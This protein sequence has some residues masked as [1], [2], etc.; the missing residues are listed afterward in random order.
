M[1]LDRPLDI[2]SIST[3]EIGGGAEKVARDLFR[4]YREQ[5]HRSTLAVGYKHSDDPDVVP[6][7][8]DRAGGAASRFFWRLHRRLQPYYGR[9]WWGTVACRLAHSLAAPARR[10]EIRRGIEDFNYPGT[11][12]LADPPAVPV[13][14][15]R[16]AESSMP[17]CLDALMPSS[18]GL[19]ASMPD[20]V[21]AHNLHGGYFDLRA[22]P[23]LSRRVPL[24][25]TLHDAWLLAGHCAHS[26]DC[27]RWRTGCGLCPDLT[28][29]PA[30]RRDATAFNWRRKRDIYRGAKLH[31]ATPCRWLMDKV[32]ASMLRPAIVE[33]RVIPYGIDL[34]VFRPADRRA[35]RR[36]LGLP[37]EAP[38]LVFAAAGIRGNAWKDYA[39]MREAVAR[40]A[41]RWTSDGNGSP[42]ID[43]N[44]SAS[45]PARDGDLLFLALGETAPHERIGRAEIR[46]VPF[47][48]D[49]RAVAAY[50]QAADV[51]VHAARADTFPNAVLEA[52]ACGTPVVATAVGGI[53]EQVRSL[54]TRVNEHADVAI[55][56]GDDATGIL[57]PQGDADALAS[58]IERLLNDAELRSRLG[59]NAAAD[60]GR[61][62]DLTR[63]VADYME[64]YR[65]LVDRTASTERSQATPEGAVEPALV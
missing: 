17:G 61:R 29:Y 16:R 12:L 31:I 52:L 7:P 47:T 59:E 46:F 28:L 36:V 63:H 45:P 43:R 35:V 26:L 14:M 22:L 8:N 34:S 27:E 41:H 4:A 39:T 44:S 37:P 54:P 5:G 15:R 55:S 50:Y 62:F 9:R 10:A 60:A 20:I 11:W 48:N 56:H 18:R 6:I 2:L 13:E 1:S 25:L 21:H 32:E 33:A 51:Y 24:V 40:L 57:V 49:P 64:W 58:A 19:D 38:I 30:V 53:P 42:R 3:R 65:D 23:S